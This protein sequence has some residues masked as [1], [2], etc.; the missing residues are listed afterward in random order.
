MLNMVNICCAV[1]KVYLISIKFGGKL[2]HW[3]GKNC[4]LVQIQ[5]CLIRRNGAILI[6]Y[7]LAS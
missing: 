4:L 2:G 6:I 5:E 7:P 3:S 1:V